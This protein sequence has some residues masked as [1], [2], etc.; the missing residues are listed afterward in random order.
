MGFLPKTSRKRRE[1]LDEVKSHRETLIFYEAPHHLKGTLKEIA[2]VL[3]GQRRAAAARELTKKFEEFC[4]GTLDELLL[5]F[6]E[7]EPRGEFVIIVSGAAE[8]SE[9]ETAEPELS[10]AELVA[11]L[12]AQ[13]LDKKSAMRETAK[14]L[15][16]SRRDVYQALLGQ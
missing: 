10:A 12:Q 4:R 2:A 14:K 1:V 9:A 13:G 16:V 3:G 5:H 6:T 15:G 11:G 8:I 7:Q